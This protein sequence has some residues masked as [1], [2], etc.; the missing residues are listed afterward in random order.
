MCTG[1]IAITLSIKLKH[2]VETSF[3]QSWALIV[4]FCDIYL[5]THLSTFVS[6]TRS[7]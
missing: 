6:Y 5:S 1:L 7:Q 2:S 4:L 3:A